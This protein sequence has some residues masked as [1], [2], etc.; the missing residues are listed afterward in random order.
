MLLPFLSSAHLLSPYASRT[1]RQEHS[2]LLEVVQAVSWD[3]FCLCASVS[4]VQ[5]GRLLGSSLEH[6]D[7]SW[8][9]RDGFV[10]F[11]WDPSSRACDVLFLRASVP[12]MSPVNPSVK[13]K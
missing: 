4:P 5:C 9:Q 3:L 13:I 12:R 10:L 8:G 1:P 6:V 2:W 7:Q 11:F